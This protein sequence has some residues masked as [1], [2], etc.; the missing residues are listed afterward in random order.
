[1]EVEQRTPNA[2]PAA[3][4][5]SAVDDRTAPTASPSTSAAPPSPATSATDRPASD[6]RGNA[7]ADG[8]LK[9]G[10]PKDGTPK[11]GPP[12]RN[13]NALRHGLYS[14]PDQQIYRLTLGTLPTWL[15]GVEDD[16]YA[17]RLAV[18]AAV[19][20]VAGSISL[21]AAHS[22]DTATRCHRHALI[23]QR[24]MR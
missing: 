4:A 13:S 2:I 17:Y 20:D 12:K 10:T 21:S 8:T 23:C 6:D 7:Q 15:A 1:M 5:S 19:Y 11:G 14:R 18:E 22:I 24:L 3:A 16:A 9:A